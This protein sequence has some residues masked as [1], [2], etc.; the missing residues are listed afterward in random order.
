MGNDI[1]HDIKYLFEP[2]SIAV[3]G[4]SQDK[5]KIGYSV[6]NNIISGGYKGRVYA[7]SPK[8]GFIDGHQVYT[9]IL[10]I[11]EEVDCASIV[12]PANLVV[13]AIKKCAE[14]KV[15]YVQIISSGFS[16][17]GN[18]REEKEIAEIAKKVGMR[19]V[20]PNMFGLYSSSVSL[21]CTFSASKVIPGHVAILTQSGALGIA[22]IG[23][24]A[25][26]GIGLS[27][28]ISI[29]N[30]CDVDE[31]DLLEYIIDH[32]DTKVIL[33]YME[34][35][36]KG[37]RLIS[38]LRRAVIKKP[39][40][41]IKSGRSERGARAAAS[42]TGSL[43][44]SD[45]IFDAIMKQCGVVRA[46]SVEEA[47][48]WC[49]FFSS[50]PAPRGYNSVII[51]NGGGIGVLATD[52]CEKYGVELCD[53]QP[54]LQ[55][56]F[57]PVTPSFGSTKNPVDITGGAAAADYE[58]ALSAAA[59]SKE[60][61]STIALYCETA[62]FDSANLESMLVSTH[63]KHMKAGKPVTYALVG[64][65]QVES[66]I[67]S[68]KT[69]SIPLFNE[70]QQAVS[71]IGAYNQYFKF[72]DEITLASEEYE[73]DTD[74]INK[75]I[76]GALKANRSF[77]LANEGAAVMQAADIVIPLSKI[78]RNIN[79]AVKYAEEIGYPVVMKVV[80]KDIL[81]KSD[82]GGVILNLETRKEVINAYEAIMHKCKGYN[83]NAVIEGIEV[84]EMVKK[85]TE[86]IIGARRDPSF[87]PVIM[88]GLGGIYVEVMKDVS[89]RTMPMNRG[90]ALSMLEDIRSYPLLLGARGEE[91][92]DI[93]SVIDT[94][95]K[96][97]SIV[98]KCGR[99]TDIEINPVVVYTDKSGLKAVDARI[100]IAKP[101]EENR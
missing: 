97:S 84:C 70:V 54:L 83:P 37:E 26:S 74:A 68:L 7:I 55:K 2:G 77:L 15:K 27:S 95:I 48:N 43:A 25:V 32:D 11:K 31:S 80:S 86:L 16:E 49:K 69:T 75:I 34:G 22:M 92:K 45:E 36:K 98:K 10:D 85:G 28:I 17:I 44:G 46:E 82:V 56:I 30:K 81:H 1:K 52:A 53:D 59:E 60:I 72:L 90:I 99:I 87:G 23:K 18:D 33:I 58:S 89:F 3:I 66:T 38:S 39:V 13:N 65:D 9:D 35:V 71:C 57:D 19:V 73:I 63:L 4:A 64:G 14:K 42:H 79:D 76:D 96:I 21:N 100:L 5:K 101:K 62:T 93:D 29:G 41:V 50:S 40:I 67:A 51:T 91:K 94:I 88:C 24:T 6:F 47:F 78:A 12:I 61:D 20:G 8:G